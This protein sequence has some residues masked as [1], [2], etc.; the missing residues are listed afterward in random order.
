M[1]K[2]KR[3]ELRNLS[4]EQLA[5]KMKELKKELVKINTQRSTGTALENPG[6]IKQLKKEIVRMLTI[7]TEKTQK[8]DE[9]KQ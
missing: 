5:S 9:K 4:I 8:E 2:S 3:N 6:R 1:K 7:I